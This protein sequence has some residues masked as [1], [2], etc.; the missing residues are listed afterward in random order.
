MTI[1]KSVLAELVQEIPQLRPQIY[2]KSSLTALSHAMEDQVLA[3]SDQPLVIATFQQERFYRQEAHRYRRIANLTSQVYVLAAPETAFKNSSEYYETIAFNTKETLSKEWNLLVLGQQYS[4]CLICNERFNSGK[5]DETSKLIAMDQARR[6]EGIWTFDRQVCVQAAE[7]LLNRILRYR[8]QLEEKVQAAREVYSINLDVEMGRKSAKRKSSSN[9]RYLKKA[10]EVVTQN[11]QFNDPFAQRL[12]TY[13]QASQYKLL[14]TYRSIAVQEQ[15][16]RLI[17]IISNAMR[18]SLDSDEIIK[19]AVQELGEALLA[20]RCLIYQCRALDVTA[21]I[22]H[23][24]LSSSVTSVVNQEWPLQD[25]PLFQRV[26][27]TQEQVSIEDTSLLPNY[28]L[29]E[30]PQSSKVQAKNCI[31]TLIS[32][33]K[34]KSWLMV[35]LLYQGRLLGMVE[36]HHCG[37]CPHNWSDDKIDL[38]EAIATQLG[39]TLIQAETYAHLEELNQQLEALDRTRSNLIAI[40]GHELRTP[41]STI[42]VCLES[43]SQEPDM[44]AELRQVMLETAL[45]DAD[46]MR[47]LVQDFLTLSHLESGTVEWNVEYLPL[48]ECVDLA[49]SSIRAHHLQRDLPNITT[50]VST[51]LPLVLAD[52]E[53]LVEVL[54][55]L[56][57]NACKFTQSEGTVMIR[58]TSNG[59]NMLEVT[60]SDTGR[61]IEPKRLEAVFDRFYQEEGA[62]RRSVGGTGLGL[63]ICRQII[64][65]LGGKIWAESAGKNRGS[66][67]H[68]T[69]PIVSNSEKMERENQTRRKES[70][71]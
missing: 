26:V 20:C 68:F 9:R 46:R 53:W 61:G 24:Y 28:C 48:L 11:P 39:I 27:Q 60:V 33:W 66:K 58:A 44:P 69:I 64:T 23:E 12:V 57:D 8:P 13:L 3:S 65:R 7:L 56:L 15:K 43:L 30:T 34:I 22:T 37:S 54:S 55:K 6:F 71:S 50:E 36:L 42:Q 41:L 32:Q 4:S 21:T 70:N 31:E 17:N 16:Q 40:T 63:A 51:E 1:P 52:G 18:R 59:D 19:V 5:S 49:L 14:K 2:F 29:T 67:F 10:S 38:V 45:A 35:P 47:N 25:N 62:L